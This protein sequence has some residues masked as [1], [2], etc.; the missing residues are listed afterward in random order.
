MSVPQANFFLSKHRKND[1]SPQNVFLLNFW[2]LIKPFQN[3]TQYLFNKYL[4]FELMIHKN[5]VVIYHL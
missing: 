5:D 2:I 3:T 4:Y 1:V